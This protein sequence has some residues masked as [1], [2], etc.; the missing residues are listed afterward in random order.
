VVGCE[1]DVNEEDPKYIGLRFMAR[2]LMETSKSLHV[3]KHV[4]PSVVILVACFACHNSPTQSLPE[5][6]DT[7]S[8]NFVWFADTLGDGTSS[9]LLSVSIVSD[10]DVWAVGQIFLKDSNGALSLPPHDVVHWDGK[11]WNLVDIGFPVY[12]YDCSLAYI[13]STTGAVTFAFNSQSILF[14][15]GATVVRWNGTYLRYYPCIPR[16]L[17]SGAIF[18]IWGNSEDDFYIVGG[19]GMVFHYYNQFWHKLETGATADIH[20]IWG[21]VE[22]GG[23]TILCAVSNQYSAGE[24]KLL[25]VSSGDVV[26]SLSW[27]PQSELKTIWFKSSS[28]IFVGGGALVTGNPAYWKVIN[29]LPLY[30]SEGI[31]GNDAND[32]FVV[33]DFGLCGHYNGSTWKSYS[34]VG[35]TDGIY[36]AVSSKSNFVVAVGQAGTRAIAIRGYRQ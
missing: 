18:G 19:G 35:L 15:D 16:S 12:N 17:Q 33:G 2:S 23:T 10:T 5:Y 28:E 7:T 22:N 4:F 6:P 14:T 3:I 11:N 25:K 9:D 8:H 34:E 24:R 20:D 30:Y 21:A 36:Y 32:V 31:R 29:D 27:S 1:G 26:G 13:Q